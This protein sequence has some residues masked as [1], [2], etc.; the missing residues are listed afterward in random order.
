MKFEQVSSSEVKG[1]QKTKLMKFLEDFRDAEI[2]VAE[3]KGWE[4][5]YSSASSLQGAV[6]NAIRRFHYDNLKCKTIDKRVYLFN[7]AV[8]E[9]N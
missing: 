7:E 1:Y 8:K 6:S 9:E 2:A 4:D 3:I 5:D